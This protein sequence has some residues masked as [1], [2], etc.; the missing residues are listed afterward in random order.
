MNIDKIRKV[1]K[2]SA[3]GGGNVLK[4]YFRNSFDVEIKDEISPLVSQ[5]DRESEIAIRK[6]VR[7][8]FPQHIVIGEEFGVDTPNVINDD[9]ITWV[10]DPLDGTSAFVA[11]IPTF[12]VLIGVWQGPKPLLGVIYQPITGEMWVGDG[13]VCTLNS[14]EVGNPPK[15]APFILATTSQDLLSPKT[16]TWFNALKEEAKVTIFG[17]DGHLYASLASGR[18]SCIIEEGLMWHDIAALVPVVE[19]AGGIITDFAGDTIKPG[20]ESYKV[21]AALDQKI[22]TMALSKLY[23]S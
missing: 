21:L 20:Q 11:G 10:L 4:K 1:S 16:Q 13:K 14:K 9:P 12:V 15:N 18:I 5:A 23:S 2:T 6:V 17:G 7:E 3:L 22:H 8:N 19:G